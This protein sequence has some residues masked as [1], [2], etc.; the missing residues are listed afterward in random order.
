MKKVITLLIC[1]LMGIN[2]FA[3]IDGFP[4]YES[5]FGHT[6]YFHAVEMSH[7]TRFNVSAIVDGKIKRITPIPIEKQLHNLF[8]I[9]HYKPFDY[10][11]FDG[12]LQVEGIETIKKTE[13]LKVSKDGKVYYFE[14]NDANNYQSYM[15]NPEVWNSCLSDLNSNKKYYLNENRFYALEW[16]LGEIPGYRYKDVCFKAIGGS[17]YL[18]TY[19]ETYSSIESKKD[20]FFSETQKSE[21]EKAK[22]RKLE[23]TDWLSKKGLIL[24]GRLGKRSVRIMEIRDSLSL[25]IGLIDDT[26]GNINLRYLRIEAKDYASF[27]QKMGIINEKFINWSQTAQKEKVTKFKKKIPVDFGDEV[28]YFTAG[29]INKWVSTE[30]FAVFEV[31]DKGN[32]SLRLDNWEEYD[33]SNSS[34]ESQMHEPYLVFCSPKDFSQLYELI[35]YDVAS[36]N[37]KRVKK[38][39]DDANR[40]INERNA[41]FD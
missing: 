3:Q 7:E 2:V 41:K 18:E 27:E 30:L 20:N 9:P 24:V 32:P 6:A 21:W 4:S 40:A 13:Y 5:M 34:Y 16:S 17:S 12:Y 37:Y 38:I 1:V 31:D 23:E 36:A 33:P 10:S 28:G 15:R 8:S 11:I 35:K 25:L 22:Q 29:F 19:G 26:D 39:V 14:I